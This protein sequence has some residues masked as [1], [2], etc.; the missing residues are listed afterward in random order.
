MIAQHSA[1]AEVAPIV[2]HHHERWNG[3]GYPAGLKGTDIPLGARIIAV[4]ESFDAIT[5][6]RVYRRSLM[7]PIAAV[8]DISRRVNHWYDPDV[9]DALREIHGLKPLKVG[10]RPEGPRSSS[11]RKRR[12]GTWRSP[13]SINPQHAG[14]RAG[15]RT[16]NLGIKSLIPPVTCDRAIANRHRYRHQ[17]DSRSSLRI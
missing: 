9:V 8:E 12:I 2:R 10:E 15:S 6:G 13:T 4:A 14:A 7:T 17:S 3:T 5:I 16:L 11:P 1:L